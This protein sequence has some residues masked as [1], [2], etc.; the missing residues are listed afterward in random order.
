M[1]KV[2]EAMPALI[3]EA[4]RDAQEKA[5]ATHKAALLDTLRH[6]EADLARDIAL[7]TTYLSHPAVLREVYAAF[8]CNDGYPPAMA[9]DDILQAIGPRKP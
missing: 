1:Q 3:E 6:D 9:G 8:A 2:S 7:I 5:T 4:F